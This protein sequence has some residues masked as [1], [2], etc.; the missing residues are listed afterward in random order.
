[1]SI[2]IVPCM[3]KYIIYY[4]K[5][6]DSIVDYF[7]QNLPETVKQAINEAW[8]QPICKEILKLLTQQD[9]ITAPVI[10]EKI[11][12]SMS[13]LH[14]NIK[15][16]EQ[17]KLIN[18]VMSYKGN[19][20]KI[21]ETNVLCISKN[22]KLTASITKFLNQ[23]LW[24]DSERSQKVVAFLQSNSDKYFSVEEI[25]AKTGI[26]VDEVQTLLNNWDS[27]ITRSF[28][29]F[30]KKSPFEKKILYKGRK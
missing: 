7:P 17:A 11:G 18:S 6:T 1:M 19:K 29:D 22:T 21:I 23:G 26:Q 8:M 13:T 15:R 10:K 16:L 14:E 27:Q 2:W 25:S 5:R 30:L 9:S 24:V 4:D 20:Q 3:T 28:S 12:H